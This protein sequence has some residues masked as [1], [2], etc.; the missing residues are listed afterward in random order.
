MHLPEHDPEEYLET[1]EK[2][3]TGE[4]FRESRSIYD[5]M[6]HDPMAERYVYIVITSIAV[7]VFLIAFIAM[8]A[9]YPLEI[10]VPFAVNS[11]DLVEDVPR[12]KSLLAHKGENPSEALL[13]FLVQNYVT[14]RE[15]YDVD[16]FER[17]VN[18]VRSQS[19]K[20]VMDRYQELIDPNNP[21][22][23]LTLYQRHSKRKIEVTSYRHLEDEEGAAE[24]EYEATVMSKTDAKK[25]RWQANIS[26][27]YSGIALDDE[28]GKVTP[29]EFIVTD[30]RTKRLQ[31]VK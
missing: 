27:K 23:P 30:Y 28:T 14:T 21:D 5:L 3:R 8:R 7:L 12:M 20:D 24:V 26:F 16:T 18:G 9:L 25:T 10:P 19:T 13:R 2:V 11:N 22:S 29:M 6:M 1:A 15:G 4:Y 31:D 17:D